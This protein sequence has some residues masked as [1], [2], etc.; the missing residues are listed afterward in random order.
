M[1]SMDFADILASSIH[2]I[3]NSLGLILSSLDDL[4]GNPDNHL[5]DPRQASLLQHEV[6]RANSNLIQLLTFYKLGHQQ[7]A[8]R[9]TDN[10]L[11]DFLE[12]IVADNQSVCRALDLDLSYDCESD[13]HGYFDAE[14]VRGVLDSTIG[15]ARRYA[16]RRIQLNASREQDF[17]VIRVEDDGSGFPPALTGLL[18]KLIDQ[19]RDSLDAGRTQLGLYFAV[20]IA[21]LHQNGDKMGRIR[22]INGHLLPGGCFE[23]WLP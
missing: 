1:D 5:S 16:K 19:P 10:N 15:N 3:K 21:Q 18:D 6:Q 17:L 9:L 23:L 14:L 4:I 11:D 2:D 8:V 22:L 20:R 7:L 12:E 13:L